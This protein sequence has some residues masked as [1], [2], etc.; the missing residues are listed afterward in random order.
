M[1]LDWS[2]VG[3][4][5]TP[6]IAAAGGAAVKDW[7]ER[8]PKLV[9][10]FGHAEGFPIRRPGQQEFAIH[11]HSIVLRNAGRK[12]A[13]NIRVSHNVLPQDFRIFPDVRHDV[14]TLPGGTRDILIPV[15][16]PGEQVTI[17]YLYFPPLLWN[18]IHAG[19]KFDEG[20]AKVLDVLP[21]PQLKGW[22]LRLI[23]ALL[24]VGTLTVLYAFFSVVGILWTRYISHGV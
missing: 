3:K 4:I 5:A 11:T 2:L 16:V 24:I 10:Y 8:K 21:T 14:E 22:Q 12:P 15:L 13:T 20:F 7:M 9:S 17:S 19:I 18:Q 1:A 23:W 6:L